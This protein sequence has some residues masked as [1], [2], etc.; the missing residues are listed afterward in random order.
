MSLG[1]PKMSLGGP[2][3]IATAKVILLKIQ[4]TRE[5]KAHHCVVHS[6]YFC[7]TNKEDIFLRGPSSQRTLIIIII[8]LM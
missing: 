5:S 7:A 4:I 3:S 1:D 6:S 2:K 8:D